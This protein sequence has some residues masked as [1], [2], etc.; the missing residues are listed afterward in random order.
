MTKIENNVHPEVFFWTPSRDL[1]PQVIPD[2]DVEWD[3][4]M[5]QFPEPFI[6]YKLTI[7]RYCFDAALAKEGKKRMNQ[8]R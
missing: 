2:S 7:S 8:L 5:G 3:L 6:S 4:A 1:N